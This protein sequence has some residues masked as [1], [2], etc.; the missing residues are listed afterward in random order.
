MVLALKYRPKGFQEIVG[1]EGVVKTLVNALQKGRIG[2]GYLFSGLRGSGKTSTARIFA[3][4]LQCEKGVSPTPC[5]TCPNCQMALENRHPDIL[6]LDAASHR[7]IEDIRELIE[8]TR[9]APTLG[10]FKIFIIDEVHMLTPEAFNAFLKTLEEPPE[11]VKFI[12]ATT[13]PLKLPATILSRVQHFR[14]GPIREE[15]IIDHLRKILEK[16]GLE[17]EEE[18]LRL[19]AKAGKGSVRDSL[20]IL[21][22]VISY[23][24]GKI[25]TRGVVEVLGVVHPELVERG[26]EGV[27]NED[28]RQLEEVIGEMERFDLESVLEEV[29]NQLTRKLRR[30]ELPLYKLHRFF[31]ILAESRE[32]LKSA[33]PNPYFFLHYLFFRL[34]EAGRPIP[35]RETLQKLRGEVNTPKELFYKLIREL[36]KRDL[37]L[38][39]CFE[40]GVKFISFDGQ[41][42]KWES[43]P[44]PQ[45][46]EELKRYF[47]LVIRPLI[48]E[49]FGKGVEIRPI[50]CPSTPPAPGL[51]RVE[52]PGPSLP[53]E[54]K[55]EGTPPPV[56]TP[57]PR[58]EVG[59]VE[60][61][62][63]RES[64]SPFTRKPSRWE[65]EL[66]TP[67]GGDSGEERGGKGP[68]LEEVKRKIYEIFGTGIELKVITPK[69][70]E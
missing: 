26:L 70:E 12:L 40:T 16:E 65:G 22:Q 60:G 21:D 10:R 30:G 14:F 55:G 28:P 29:E 17:W 66:G 25:E 62:L 44:E 15:L 1:Q 50:K 39:I 49:I 3:R 41:V 32:L 38:G 58:V 19:I 4:A 61:G 31:N 8:E 42:L 46:R 69:K 45:C 20:T 23:S 67:T 36:K 52:N 51:F 33:S 48:D 63:Y 37:K 6:E 35:V 24:G 57:S 59:E 27:F 7:R 11:Y 54:G 43:C 9:Y 64:S 2:S 47:N 5:G 13:D 68:T 34:L 56:Q 18:G 53:G